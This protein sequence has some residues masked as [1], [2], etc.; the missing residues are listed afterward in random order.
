VLMWV[1]IPK[2]RSARLP[3]NNAYVL[4]NAERSWSLLLTLLDVPHDDFAEL[5]HQACRGGH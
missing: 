2:W 4:R 5:L 1:I 3:A